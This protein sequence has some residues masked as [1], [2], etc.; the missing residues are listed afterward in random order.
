MDVRLKHISGLGFDPG[1]YVTIKRTGEQ[2]TLVGVVQK[3][4]LGGF[5]GSSDGKKE[6]VEVTKNLHIADIVSVK[7]NPNVESSSDYGTVVKTF[8]ILTIRDDAGF[9]YEAHLG[10]DEIKRITPAYNDLIVILTSQ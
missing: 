8:I 10:G 6:K 5:K 2:L 1:S 4:S 9:T 7:L 3:E